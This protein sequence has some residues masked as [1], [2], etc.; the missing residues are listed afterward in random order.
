MIAGAE[1]GDRPL[2][3]VA[4]DAPA[5]LVALV[6]TDLPLGELADRL[7]RFV[8]ATAAAPE[9]KR[10]RLRLPGPKILLPVAAAFLVAAAILGLLWNQERGHRRSAERA[11]A[12]ARAESSAGT[13]FLAEA[14]LASADELAADRFDWSA[15][16]HG[17]AALARLTQ[18]RPGVN[19]L[20]AAARGHALWAALGE[21][22]GLERDR[23]L[24]APIAAV[25]AG[26]DLVL[27]AAG[28]TVKMWRA[29]GEPAGSLVGHKADVVSLAV[30]R[31]GKRAV[32]SAPGELF[33][34]HLDS[35]R[36]VRQLPRADQ[37]AAADLALS[38]DGA[39]LLTTEHD[40]TVGLWR[41]DDPAA[42]DRPVPHLGHNGPV[43]AVAFSAAGDLF[44]SAGADGHV[45]LWETATGRK[46]T[47]LGSVSG[48][49]L[50]L[51][52]S[53]DGNHIAVASSNHTVVVG[54]VP[55]GEDA[56]GEPLVGHRDAVRSVTFTPDGALIVAAGADGSVRAWHRLDLATA[57]AL[58]AH[59]AGAT[60]VAA[61]AG[62][63]GAR[64]LS[65]GG[66]GHLRVW[67]LGAGARSIVHDGTLLSVA[68][69]AGRDEA[70]LGSSDRLQRW[71]LATG[72]IDEPALLPGCD[73]A[74]AIAAAPG[75]RFTA[76]ACRSGAVR[77][78]D[79]KRSQ[80]L[81]PILDHG[82]ARV[83]AFSPDGALLA[84]GGR[85]G[86]VRLWVSESTVQ[87]AVLRAKEG[88]V[89]ALAFSR[90]G[91]RLA[92][93]GET[94][95]LQVWTRRE[96]SAVPEKLLSGDAPWRAL[97]FS[98]DGDTL[99]AAE[100]QG[101]VLIH[102]GTWAREGVGDP[103][104]EI[105]TIRIAADG[106]VLAG[107]D[108]LRLV[109]FPSGAPLLTLPA[110]TTAIDLSAT[111]LLWTDGIRVHTA[112]L[113]ALRTS[114]DAAALR[115]AAE[116]ATGLTLDGFRPVRRR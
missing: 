24:A 45:I 59:D 87:A 116:H 46:R 43:L 19:A 106:A 8:P 16:L 63:D 25:A 74:H 94:G 108:H 26:G 77:L 97:A 114:A 69:A 65:G 58:D 36:L 91:A 12:T 113:S 41:L 29:G 56:L 6:D 101:A 76:A 21:T 49:P 48:R 32:S 93:A 17:A 5:G 82:G 71:N 44:A 13:F 83:L 22:R 20:R 30:S 70:L 89:T 18:E 107:R 68:L 110:R 37:D 64:L 79:S 88:A 27:T 14:L 7:D 98:P 85:D 57:F 42:G 9:A 84:T 103:H 35:R 51:A 61:L 1:K 54:Y 115:T 78:W 40:G 90:D 99:L 47:R 3:E 100:R 86:T 96:K 2:A 11:A 52:F 66:D 39:T 95:W 60:G 111:N 38:P 10:A 104:D 102:T 15:A 80:E 92:A 55:A 109:A 31:D 105:H 67:R 50:D 75:G 53:P 34:W 33:V 28:H 23:D 4:P 81:P 73:Q 112:P 72:A 62:K